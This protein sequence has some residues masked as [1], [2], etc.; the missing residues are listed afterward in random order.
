M[1][2]FLK[3]FLAL[4][5]GPAEQW[6]QQE[7]RG[8][9]RVECQYRCIFDLDGTRCPATVSDLGEGGLRLTIPEPV[10]VGKKLRVFCPFV[11]VDGPSGP[12]EGVVCWTRPADAKGLFSLGLR[13]TSE[14]RQLEGSWVT[15]VL[16]LLGFPGHTTRHWVGLESVLAGT[17]GS[18]V[19]EVHDLGIGGA[20]L[21]SA[22]PLA[23]GPAHLRINPW[24]E[25]PALELGGVIA[26]ADDGFRFEFLETE[27]K[28]LEELTAYLR[29]LLE[30]N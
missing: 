28:Q 23:P 9:V 6:D 12:I 24:N 10:A 11:D 1:T 14:P 22:E 30:R 2:D 17:V 18:Q 19:V 29:A 21:K 3:G 7:R 5:R 27:D 15:W 26:T 16:Q 20:L 4:V 8:Q 25:L 13:Y